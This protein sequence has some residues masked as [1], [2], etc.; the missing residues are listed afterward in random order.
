MMFARLTKLLRQLFRSEPTHEDRK[1]LM[2][3]IADAKKRHA[4]SR[5]L[6]TRLQIATLESLKGEMK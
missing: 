5:H 2:R 4:A 3:R 6:Q 1:D